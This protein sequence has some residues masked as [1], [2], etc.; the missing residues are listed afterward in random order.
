MSKNS[1]TLNDF[2]ITILV[3]IVIILFILVVYY[4]RK[5]VLLLKN[6]INARNYVINSAKYTHQFTNPVYNETTTATEGILDISYRSESYNLEGYD[7]INTIHLDDC[8][9]DETYSET[10][11]E[12]NSS[13]EL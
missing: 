4:T 10:Y 9:F 8:N 7:N 6:H 5:L 13:S 1:E 11:S 12:L 2:H 3:I